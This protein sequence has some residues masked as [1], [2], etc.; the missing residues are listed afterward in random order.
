MQSPIS[1]SLT[2]IKHQF[3]VYLTMLLQLLIYMVLNKVVI[4]ER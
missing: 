1:A 4:S 2:F 3:T